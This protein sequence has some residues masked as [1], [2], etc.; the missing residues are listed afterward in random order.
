MIIRQHLFVSTQR[1]QFFILVN[2]MRWYKLAFETT[3][4]AAGLRNQKNCLVS[5]PRHGKKSGEFWLRS[6]SSSSLN[7]ARVS[8]IS[9]ER[10][11]R[12]RKKDNC[13][14][15]RLYCV[16]VYFYIYNRRT[17]N[18]A[19]RRAND[20]SAERDS[21]SWN[22]KILAQSF[23][24]KNIE[25][26]TRSDWELLLLHD[27]VPT[28]RQAAHLRVLSLARP[29]SMWLNSTYTGLLVSNLFIMNQLGSFV[30]L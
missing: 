3:M 26:R 12:R 2:L 11:R 25:T 29:I 6:L 16:R 24:Y 21:S 23:Y 15:A 27:V 28:G 13:L 30:L 9:R 7:N 17:S 18:A 22:Q 20:A 1:T 19:S 14:P 10:R 8:G 5:L 4:A